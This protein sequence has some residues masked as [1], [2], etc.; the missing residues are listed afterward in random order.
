MVPI[1]RDDDVLDA[2]RGAVRRVGGE[3]G[4]VPELDPRVALADTRLGDPWAPVAPGTCFGFVV[5]PVTRRRGAG[6][7]GVTW[8]T[9]G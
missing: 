6:V 4:P 5:T 7:T 9:P 2:D 1:A 8:G 3:P